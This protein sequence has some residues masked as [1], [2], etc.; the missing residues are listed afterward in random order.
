MPQDNQALLA[1]LKTAGLDFVVIGGVCC[2][3]HGVPI[4][5]YDLDICCRFDESSVRKIDAALRDLHPYHRLT[6]QRLPF[7][8]TEELLAG[9][10]NLYLETDLGRLDCL[11]EVLGVGDYEAALRNSQLATLSYGTF[12]FLD[13]DSLITSK[14]QAGRDRDLAALRHLKP[15]REK[16][17]QQSKHPSK[18]K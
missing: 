7:V 5:T 16:L 14:E 13:L 17:N 6:P 15:I 10:K 12:H 11:G 8:V 9:L 3:Y 2:V 18:P 4:A 1:R